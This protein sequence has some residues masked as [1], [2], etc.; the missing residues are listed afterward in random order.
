MNIGQCAGGRLLSWVAY[1]KEFQAVKFARDYFS[2]REKNRLVISS[3][4]EL[5]SFSSDHKS[6]PTLVEIQR[7][8][9]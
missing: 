7:T 8:W 5:I 4:Q 2:T 9:L 1:L 3:I 6:A